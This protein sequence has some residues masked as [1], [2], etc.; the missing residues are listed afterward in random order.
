LQKLKDMKDCVSPSFSEFVSKKWV[1]GN[2]LV[3]HVA[4]KILHVF[5]KQIGTVRCQITPEILKFSIVFIFVSCEKRIQSC[6]FGRT[7]WFNFD[8]RYKYCGRSRLMHG[9]GKNTVF[10]TERD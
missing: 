4:S 6:R 10:T 5:W 7:A 1:T 3:D 2:S 9:V 8:C